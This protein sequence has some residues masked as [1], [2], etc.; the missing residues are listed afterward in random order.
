MTLVLK[1]GGS[2]ITQKDRSET[3]D[4]AALERTAAAVGEAGV[5]DLVLVHGGGSF[6]HHHAQ[7]HGVTRSVGTHDAGAI[8]DIH[9]AMATLCD[10]V[11][12]ALQE[13]GVPALPVHPLSVAA[14]TEEG[15]AIPMEAIETLLTEGFVP[16]LHGD[17]IGHSGHGATIVSGDELVVSIAESLDADRVG[18]CSAVPGVL[19]ETGKVVPSIEDRAAVGAALGE[20]ETT[21]VT[22]G[23]AAK[24]DVLLAGSTPAWI[25][26]VDDLPA[27]LAGENPGTQ[28]GPSA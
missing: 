15:L 24:V 18:L 9:G 10:A 23:M 16:V 11:V 8:R 1:L 14:R 3:V 13:S 28:V 12:A 5:E 20:S 7:R 27:F 21:D 4:S 19:D 6:G 22:G 17:V 26:G 25:F 2:V